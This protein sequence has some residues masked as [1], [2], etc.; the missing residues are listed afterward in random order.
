MRFALCLGLLL[1]STHGWLASEGLASGLLV[2]NNE[3][4]STE[5]QSF[6]AFGSGSYL[7]YP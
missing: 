2:L 1:G 3:Q 4:A 5:L 7:S 6:S